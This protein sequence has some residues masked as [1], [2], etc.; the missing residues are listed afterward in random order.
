MSI[1]LIRPLE[2]DPTLAILTPTPTSPAAW[3]TWCTN[4]PCDTNCGPRQCDLPP[5]K[6][7][8]DRPMLGDPRTVPST[9]NQYVFIRY[10]VMRPHVQLPRFPKVL[11]VNGPSG[12]G[13][14]GNRGGTHPEL[15]VQSDATSGDENLGMQRDS[16]TFNADLRLDTP[17]HTTPHV[18]LLPC[19]FVSALTPTSRIGKMTTRVPLRVTHSR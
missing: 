7:V 10:C 6:Q 18:W 13:F 12:P 14:G 11:R 3:G 8:I 16:T 15:T 19:L 5:N 4:R 1:S 9:F 2:P 17:V